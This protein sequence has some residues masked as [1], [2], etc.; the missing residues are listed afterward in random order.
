MNK[1][2]EQMNKHR[3]VRSFTE[4]SIPVAHI[5]AAVAA[6]QMASTSSAVQA[7]CV[8]NVTDKAHRERLVELTGGQKKVAQ[9][10][11]FFVICGDTR[12]HRLILDKCADLT[13][14]TQF[15]AFMVAL[16]DTCLFAQNLALAFESLNYGICYIGGLRNDLPAVDQLLNIPEGVYPFFGMCVGVE[17]PEAQ[18]NTANATMVRP[19]LP[20][21]AVCFDDSYPTDDQVYSLIDK[22]D[23]AYKEYIAARGN[24]PKAWSESIKG[25]FSGAKR[26]ELADYYISKGANLT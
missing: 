4:E 14:T 10:G 19:R 20:F 23:N 17:M 3:S 6:G 13:Y 24:Q 7:Y 9:A 12:R 2:I 25:I 11:A 21:A 15:E 16:I 18:Q 26:S 1:V 5:Q 22:Y 8:I